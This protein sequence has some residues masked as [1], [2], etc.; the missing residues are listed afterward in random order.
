M[1]GGG[2]GGHHISVVPPQI[3][4]AQ[5]ATEGQWS[6]YLTPQLTDRAQLAFAALPSG[7]YDAI[8]AVVL[9][10]YEEAYRKKFRSST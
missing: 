7:D 6:Q 5:T 10:R 8:K 9:A 4:N 3:I 2:E 1:G